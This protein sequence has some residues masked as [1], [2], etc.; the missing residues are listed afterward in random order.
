MKVEK[1]YETQLRA[2]KGKT[3]AVVYIF[4]N[5]DAP[6]FQH[7]WVWKGDIIAGWLRAIQELECLPF[8]LDVRTFI[9]KAINRTLPNIDFVINLNCGSYQLSSMS[10]VPSMC[11]FL[12]I[13]C[14][15]CDAAAIVM[16]ENKHISNLLALAKNLNVPEYLT[17]SSKNGI[18]R[19]LNLGSSIGVKKGYYENFK[20][21]GIYQKFIPGY[22]I[23][24][25][26]VYNPL[27]QDIDLLPPI[28]YFPSSRDPNWI[29]DAEE[30]V[31]DDGF[32]SI[33]IQKI[34]DNLKKEIIEFAHIFPIQTFGRIDARI[35]Y[36]YTELSEEVV[37]H[38]LRFE[39]LYFIEINSMPTIEAG[40]SFE[41]SYKA[42]LSDNYHSF[43][44]CIKLYKKFTVCSTIN[45]FLLSCSMIALTKAKC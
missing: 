43:Y 35:N 9:Q 31:K 29:Y 44:N 6:G 39:D 41:T 11:S 38:Q 21:G 15:P 32:I 12:A 23:T 33:P 34:E 4:E 36:P 10:L 26:I 20:D 5:E 18:Y 24:I 13:P 7:Y 22:D 8:I 25:P 1:I 14:I 19:P 2:I 30:K 27:I 17:A 3:V 16:S 28:L 40:D 37:K 42:V 45:S